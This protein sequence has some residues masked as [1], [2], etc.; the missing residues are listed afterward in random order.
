MSEAKRATLPRLTVN[1]KLQYCRDMVSLSQEYAL[2]K[3]SE[4][5]ME[6]A[7]KLAALWYQ[8]SY[9]GDCWWVKQYGI[10]NTQ[11]SVTVGTVDFVAHA[12]N[13]LDESAKSTNFQLK[14]KSLLGLAFIRHGEPWYFEGWDDKTQQYYDLTD[15]RLMPQSRQYKAMR[16]L[17]NFANANASRVDPF[18]TRCDVLK[19]FSKVAVN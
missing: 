1:K 7:Y 17:A 16:A 9:E 19:K 13:L 14:E 3:P 2:M 10:S 5:R 15:L 12:L 11:D 4:E 6:K 8:G 18:V